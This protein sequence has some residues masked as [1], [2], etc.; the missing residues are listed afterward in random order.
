MVFINILNITPDRT[1]IQVSVETGVDYNIT[2]IK[3]WDHTTFK[4]ESLAVDLNY[5]L[6]NVN[7]KEVF[8]LDAAEVNR[9]TFDG[10]FFMEFTS[11]QPTSE[12]STCASTMLGVTASLKTI[13]DCI[14]DKVLALSVCDGDIFTDDSCNGNEGMAILNLHMLMSSMIMAL[15]NGHFTEAI[16]IYN[17]LLKLCKVQDCETCNQCV[18]CSTG[19]VLTGLGYGTLG[20]SLILM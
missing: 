17:T 16:E 8:I 9:T 18:N 13:K 6:E 7:N 12:C 5:K 14:L 19:T 2:G 1:K 10:I 15:E 20:N 11:N 3:Y 4:K